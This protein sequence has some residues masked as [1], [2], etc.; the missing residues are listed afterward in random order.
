MPAL[1]KVCAIS[2]NK[3][4]TILLFHHLMSTAKHGRQH[5]V[6]LTCQSQHWCRIH[7][8]SNIYLDTTLKIDSTHNFTICYIYTLRLQNILYTKT[9]KKHQYWSSDMFF[10]IMK[11]RTS[12]SLCMV[13]VYCRSSYDSLFFLET[14]VNTNEHSMF[15]HRDHKMACQ[16]CLLLII[17]QRSFN[18]SSMSG[19]YVVGWFSI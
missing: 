4:T 6:L 8:A 9:R 1:P 2:I 5:W 15:T 7:I 16:Y 13:H 18:L 11:Y 17:K 3:D 12:S 10:G 14:Q 19:V